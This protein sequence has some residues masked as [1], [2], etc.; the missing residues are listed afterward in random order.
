MKKNINRSNRKKPDSNGKN[1]K[2]I[3]VEKPNRSNNSRIGCV[4][5][6][7]AKADVKPKLRW[8]VQNLLQKLESAKSAPKQPAPDE[9]V[10]YHIGIDLGDKKSHYC[11]LDKNANIVADGSLATTMIEFELYF[12]EIPRSRIAFE[13]GTHSPW[14]NSLLEVIG[15]EV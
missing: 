15:H 4:S 10:E 9:N 3:K 8:G 2:A 5:K 13:V 12:R 11:I 14:I 6:Q 1:K 7:H